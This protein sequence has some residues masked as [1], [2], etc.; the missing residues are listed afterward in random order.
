[1][2]D[3]QRLTTTVPVL[4]TP[5]LDWEVRRLF[6]QLSP[7]CML[8][9]VTGS[10]KRLWRNLQL[11]IKAFSSRETVGAVEERA[12]QRGD[13]EIALRIYTPKTLL[14]QDR[15]PSLLWIHGGGFVLGDLYTAG[16]TCRK[17]ANA[18]G[19]VVVAV[20]YRLAPEHSL[21]AGLEDCLRAFQWLAVHATDLG[22]DPSKIAVG[23]DSAG[24]TLAALVAQNCSQTDAPRPA[25]QLLVYPATDLTAS[26]PDEESAP[27]SDR[28]LAMLFRWLQTQLPPSY[29]HDPRLSPARA[30]ALKDL[31]PTIMV[32]AGF[33]P[34]RD[35]A[36]A[37]AGKLAKQGVGVRVIHFPGQFHGFLIFDTVLH[38]ARLAF[39]QIGDAL[40]N[41]FREGRV[42]DGVVCTEVTQPASWGWLWLRP[43]QRLRELGVVALMG[44]D[45]LQ[46]V[47]QAGEA[48]ST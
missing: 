14:R 19:C 2:T 42:E 8:P 15:R 1:M 18:C 4:R 17:L 47:T 44:C 33:D 25:A 21:H 46:S 35:D 23:G 22:L 41:V 7:A 40:S 32:T 24:G 6:L 11:C 29:L 12:F 36:L 43:S 45:A 28:M 38:G 34:L 3:D 26:Y 20:S 9:M 10:V 13:C 37:Y 30:S 5:S 27:V 31:P 48:G 39:A 16:A